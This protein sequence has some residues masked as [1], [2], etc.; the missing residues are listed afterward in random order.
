MSAGVGRVKISLLKYLMKKNEKR[1]GQLSSKFA[2]QGLPENN[3]W[4]LGL[5]ALAFNWCSIT[6]DTR[7]GHFTSLPEKLPLPFGHPP[8][9][10]V[11][12]A[13]GFGVRE[14]RIPRRSPLRQPS[15]TLE[16]AAR[17]WEGRGGGLPCPQ[18]C[19]PGQLAIPDALRAATWKGDPVVMR[20]ARSSHVTP[21][22][23]CPSAA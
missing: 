15:C 16:V 17:E 2:V 12:C 10:P 3:S 21:R 18:D 20:R 9:V 11:E 19:Q 7:V 5:C 4:T 1:K 23:L 6:A 8:A 14:H 22:R 13:G